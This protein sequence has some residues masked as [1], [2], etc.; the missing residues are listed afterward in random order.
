MPNTER[1]IPK[2]DEED[3]DLNATLDRCFHTAPTADLIL[4][5]P[6]SGNGHSWLRAEPG[7]GTLFEEG[8]RSQTLMWEMIASGVPRSGEE[9]SGGHSTGGNRGNGEE[10]FQ[11]AK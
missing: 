9:K 3:S 8:L 6:R 10:T 4:D 11:T 5:R 7:R 2:Q 1:K